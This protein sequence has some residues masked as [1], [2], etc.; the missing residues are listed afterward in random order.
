MKK[1]RAINE[2]SK[3]DYRILEDIE[4]IHGEVDSPRIV[5]Q[6]ASDEQIISMVLRETMISKRIPNNLVATRHLT[7]EKGQRALTILVF[8]FLLPFHENVF[9]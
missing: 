3:A 8:S 6:V 4:K 5:T 1:Y 7:V 2:E 9:F